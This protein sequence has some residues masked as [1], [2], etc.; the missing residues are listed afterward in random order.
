GPQEVDAFERELAEHMG[1]EHAL[2]VNAG[3]SALI[4]G[5]IGAGVG[6][7]DE[8]IVPAYTWN[9]TANAVLAAGALPVLAEV[10]DSLTLDPADAERK[11]TPRTGARR[12]RLPGGRC[13]VRG[14]SPR[15]LRRRGRVQ[16]PVQQDHH[17]RRGRGA[18][19]EPCR[20]LRHGN[21]GARLRRPGAPGR[22]AAALPGLE[23]P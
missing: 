4:C 11:V 9:A 12:G 5:L 20:P 18:D 8:V 21:R 1:A 3:S 23:L 6:R 15:K 19:H 10:D 7:G 17:D 2:A 22:A 14:P 16:P 13:L